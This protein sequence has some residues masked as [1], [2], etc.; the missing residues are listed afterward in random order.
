MD[1]RYFLSA[2]AAAFCIFLFFAIVTSHRH[3]SHRPPAVTV[4]QAR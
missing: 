2:L 4:S 1:V 3:I